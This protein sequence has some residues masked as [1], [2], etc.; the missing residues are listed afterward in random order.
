M[1][2]IFITYLI[3]SF[4]GLLFLLRGCFMELRQMPFLR[5]AFNSVCNMVEECSI[6]VTD[7]LG[8]LPTFKESKTIKG[9]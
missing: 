4:L 2:K 3:V 7:I 8:I 5:L 9:F 6:P 1:E